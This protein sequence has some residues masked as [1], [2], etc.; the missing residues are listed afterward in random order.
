MLTSTFLHLPGV[1]EATETHIWRRGL[2]TWSD[3]LS[4][5]EAA[6]LPAGL[7]RRL[8]AHLAHSVERLAQQD[9]R[10]FA[11]CLPRREHWRAFPEFAHR[12]AY[13]DIE[14]TSLE[15]DDITLIGLYDGRELRI[16]QKGENLHQFLEDISRFSLLV[17]FHGSGFDL[18]FL[19]RRFPGLEFPQLH[20]DLCPTLRRLGLRGGLKAIERALGIPRSP[21][22][23]G[24]DGW[25]AVRLWR[26]WERGSGEALQLLRR[27]HAEDVLHLEA[28]M[29]WAYPRLRKLV[30]LPAP[31]ETSA[32]TPPL[33]SL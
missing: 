9:H 17:T 30:G 19:R 6:G 8:V 25:D 13:L 1:G 26:E 24:L 18:P 5:P 10:F 29:H 32:S 21:E 31:T 33:S 22:T 4:R 7:T 15:G 28:L 14:T 3:F 23:Q 12:V 20:V 2:H 16:Y 11:C 27:Y